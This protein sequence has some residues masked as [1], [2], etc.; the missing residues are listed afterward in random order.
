M[1]MSPALLAALRRRDEDAIRQVAQDHARRL[2]RAARGL[3]HAAPDADD[4]VQDVFVTFMATL[5]RFEGRSSVQTWLFGILLHKSRER[6]RVRLKDER[7]D[8]IDEQWADTFDGRGSWIRT[9]VDPDRSLES[10]EAGHAIAECL[11]G[12]PAQ[13]RDVF[14]LR[15]VEHL[16]TAE[17]GKILGLT[18]T[19]TGVLLHRAR[20]RMRAC[21]GAKG[22][23][24]GAS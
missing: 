21:L 10:D 14:I 11:P 18:V 2:Y 23:S 8:P 4:L 24:M 22:W 12:L 20:L 13:Q 19:H 6:R 15:L 5:D 3:G 7:H 1:S 17:V 16:T 9:P